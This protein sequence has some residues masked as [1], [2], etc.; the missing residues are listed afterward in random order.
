MIQKNLNP[1]WSEFQMN[2]SDVG[3]LDGILTFEVYDWD[4][5]GA[6]ELVGSL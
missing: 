5:R 3:G 2:A 1:Q 6:D 4:Q